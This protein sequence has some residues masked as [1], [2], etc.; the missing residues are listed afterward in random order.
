MARVTFG[1]AVLVLVLVLVLETHG[2]RQRM[3]FDHERLD[4]YRVTVEFT[5]WCG[6]L[7]DGPLGKTHLSV[8]K[9]LE[10]AS[11]SIS[12]NIAEGNGKRSSKD[13][14][15]YFDTARGSALECAGC[16]DVLVARKQLQLPDVA[17]GK[18]LLERVVGMLSK[19]TLK[20]LGS[21]E[22]EHEHE[23]EHGRSHA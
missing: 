23:H 7:L 10:R 15:R 18:A 22:H 9:Q 8:I 13:R 1:V 19:M 4:V 14:C 6:A 16:L 12:L 2:W 3:A 5:C 17:S 20:L 11:T 21:L